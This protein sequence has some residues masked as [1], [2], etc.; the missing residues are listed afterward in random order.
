MRDRTRL[1][2]MAA[3]VMAGVS[4]GNVVRESRS[5]MLI[6]I[7]TLLGASGAKPTEFGNPVI[8]DVLT[9]VTSGGTCTTTSPC[10]TVFND[11][12][13]AVLRLVPKDIGT[14]T[15]PATPSTNNDVTI[16]RYRVV[17]RRTDGRNTQGVDVPF[18]FDG[19][20]TGT[21]ASTGTLTLAFE[22][23]RNNAKGEAPLVQLVRNFTIINAI[24]DV[25]FFGTDRVGNA[26]SAT[27][28]IGVNFGNFG[29]P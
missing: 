20:A 14:P 23:V 7:D 24:A 21:V 12:G 29:D 9:L 15:S 25:T 10:P 1:I 3:L 5:P 11:L 13:Q 16:T 17:Y 4:C 6:T 19:A 8:S 2:G 26:V 27:G 18:A 22:I 28:S